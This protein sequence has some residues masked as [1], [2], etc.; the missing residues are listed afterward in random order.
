MAYGCLDDCGRGGLLDGF[1]CRGLEHGR[2]NGVY[3]FGDSGFG[4]LHQDF[5]YSSMIAR[6]LT[7]R[8]IA[9]YETLTG[10]LLDRD[11]I[12]LL[13]GVMRLSELAEYAQDAR[14]ATGMIKNVAEWA[15]R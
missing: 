14:H 8:I 7:A 3:D 1:L 11:R 10:R 5:I 2:L 9:E 12:E 15:A 4:S 13:T 6:E